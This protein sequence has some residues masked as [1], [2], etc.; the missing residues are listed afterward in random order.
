MLT[1]SNPILRQLK[2]QESDLQQI[3]E[4]EKLSFNEYDAY[5][6]ED[7][8]RFFCENPDL[9]IVAEFDNR[10]VGDMIAR[11]I[12]DKL[13]LVSFVIHPSYRRFGIGTALLDCT[14]Q[15]C[16]DYRLIQIELEVRKSNFPGV[17]FWKKM[18]FNVFGEIKQFYGDG[19]DALQMRKIINK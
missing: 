12:Q 14:I 4:I 6:L 13:D 11:K 16:R 10:I 2:W 19:E 1:T 18:G 8:F 3:L 15:K 7:Y 9:C 17:S 5:T